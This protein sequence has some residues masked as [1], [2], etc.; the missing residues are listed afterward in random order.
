MRSEEIRRDG[1]PVA[2]S[3]ATYE[4]LLDNDETNEGGELFITDCIRDSCRTHVP[5]R[6]IY[7]GL[8]QLSNDHRWH[9][10]VWWTVMLTTELCRVRALTMM[11]KLWR[12][13]IHLRIY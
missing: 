6:I 9:D 8:K 3:V 10:V 2:G 4:M 1:V 12:L 11:S 13:G 7:M 5:M